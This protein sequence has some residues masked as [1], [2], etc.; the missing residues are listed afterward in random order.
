MLVGRP[1]GDRRWIPS[2]QIFQMS[3]AMAL[4]S[5]FDRLGIAAILV[6]AFLTALAQSQS[7]P[8]YQATLTAGPA[9]RRSRTR[10]P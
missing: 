9:A 4:G 3:M 6:I 7:A 10:W 1:T 5:F 2:S 8:T